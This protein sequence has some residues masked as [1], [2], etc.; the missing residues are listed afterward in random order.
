MLILNDFYI[1]KLN[2]T[3]PKFSVQFGMVV[4]TSTFNNPSSRV[5]TTLQR[6][7][8]IPQG[9]IFTN[10][11]HT[12]GKKK[13][14]VKKSPTEHQNVTLHP[15]LSTNQT[16]THKGWARGRARARGKAAE[17]IIWLSLWLFTMASMISTNCAQFSGLRRS[18]PTQSYSQHVNSHLRLVSSRRPRRSSSV[19]AMASSNKVLNFFLSKKLYFLV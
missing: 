14:G 16:H 6:I 12:I 11:D 3:E 18:S 7:A 13:K 10:F 4:V 5:K 15:T 8:W 2:R 19:V 17:I 9:F 1:W